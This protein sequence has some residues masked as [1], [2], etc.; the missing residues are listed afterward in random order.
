LAKNASRR[1][2]RAQTLKLPLLLKTK[3][4]IKQR[5]QLPDS[6]ALG[7]RLEPLRKRAG[8]VPE[9]EL[10]QR[11]EIGLLKLAG[12]SFEPVNE[13]L[14]LRVEGRFA[15]PV[16]LKDALNPP[17]ESAIAEDA[18]RDRPLTETFLSQCEDALAFARGRG[19]WPS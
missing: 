15:A 12:E 14:D 4:E 1:S 3:L 6:H 16:R 18:L 17:S 7:R 13:R 2:A 8:F 11:R 10:L 5:G 9:E 19:W